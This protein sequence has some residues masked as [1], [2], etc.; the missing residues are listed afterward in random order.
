MVV[1]SMTE[2][3]F[4]YKI[5]QALLLCSELRVLKIMTISDWVLH[6]WVHVAFKHFHGLELLVLEIP[7]F[8]FQLRDDMDGF[9]WGYVDM[10]NK[11]LGV[12]GRLL[13]VETGSSEFWTWKHEDCERTL[14]W[15]KSNCT[16][17]CI[18]KLLH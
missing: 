2:K 4:R 8:Y 7:A 5:P 18:M 9:T 13:R 15:S 17:R 11:H 10:T 6:Q 1:N 14:K 12:K 3:G 16:E